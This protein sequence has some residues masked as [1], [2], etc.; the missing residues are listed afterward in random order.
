MRSMMATIVAPGGGNR[1]GSVLPLDLPRIS[2]Q[3]YVCLPVALQ[4]TSEPNPAREDATMPTMLGTPRRCCDGITRRE[5]LKA[6]ALTALGGLSLADVLRAEESGRAGRG[7]A[8]SVIML[9]LLGGAPHQDMFDM[10]PNA[11]QEVRGEFKPIDTN[12]PGIQ[13]CEHLPHT[14]RWMHRAAIIRSANHKAGCHNTLPS[15]TGYEQFLDNIV[16]TKDSYPPSMG[17]VCEYLKPADQ[18]D[19]AYVYM[20]CSLGWGQSIERPGPYAGFLGKR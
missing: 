10:K 12:V 18:Q 7:K 13:V 3:K 15:Y 17:S 19:P 16:S 6:G 2:A 4:A 9:Y 1:A 5:T 8:K 20:P 11:P 14:A